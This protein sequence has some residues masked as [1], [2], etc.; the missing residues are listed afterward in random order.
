MDA[1]GPANLAGPAHFHTLRRVILHDERRDRD[2]AVDGASA[3][4]GRDPAL[5]LPFDPDDDVVSAVHARVWRETDGSWWIEDLGS[6]NGTW[7]NGRRI[8]AA[9]PLRGGDRV[10]LGQRGPALRVT[11]PDEV[12]RTRTE[13]AADAGAA[14]GGRSRS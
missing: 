12:P 5:E 8:A 10:T 14:G 11:I 4:L 3:R 7:L 6:T 13:P 1:Q 9:E 2:L